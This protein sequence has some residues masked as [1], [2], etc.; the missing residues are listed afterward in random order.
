MLSPSPYSLRHGGASHDRSTNSRS[1][2]DV[3]K[4]GN[5]KAWQSVRRYEKS[6]RLG[7]ELRKLTP[8]TLRRLRQLEPYVKSSLQ[9]HFAML[10]SKAR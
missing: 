8:A 2:Q 7:M 4:R 3:R 6:G 10:D 5:W 1:I 9:K